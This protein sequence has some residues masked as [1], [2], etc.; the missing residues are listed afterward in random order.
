MAAV[1][2]DQVQI[3]LELRATKYLQDV[4]RAANQFDTDMARMSAA[5]GG[6]E[7][8]AQQAFSGIRA[9]GLSLAGAFSV[10]EILSYADA[11]ANLNKTLGNAGITGTKQSV[12]M[13]QL[14]QS[15][16]KNSVPL[17]DLVN[18]YGKVSQAQG[19]LGASS[20][21]M[22]RFVDGVAKALQVAG[23]S[24]T[25][26][27]GALLQL[28]QALG[29]GTIR[30]EEFNSI[31]EGARPVLQAVANA[32][33]TVG[34]SL[35]KL[36]DLMASG[37]LS[38]KE[39]FEAFNRGIDSVAVNAGQSAITVSQAVVKIQNA[40]TKYIGQTDESLGAT[41]RLAAG[42]SALADNFNKTADV[43]LKLVAVIAAAM[44]GRA[45]GPMIASLG[46]G[47]VA[48]ARFSAAVVSATY[49]A[50]GMGAAFRVV[51]SAIVGLGAAA[52]PVG[53][54]IAATLA[55]AVVTYVTSTDSATASTTAYAA[56][57]KKV[58]EQAAA[59]APAIADLNEKML[60]AQRASIEAGIEEASKRFN[61]AVA[62]MRASIDNNLGAMAGQFP[63]MGPQIA[64]VRDRL[65]EVVDKLQR[66]EIDAKQAAAEIKAIGDAN[67]IIGSLAGTFG[68][69]AGRIGDAAAAARV[70]AADLKAV[71]T[72]SVE[73][74]MRALSAQTAAAREAYGAGA[75]IDST[76]TQVVPSE[77]TATPSQI[78]NGAYMQN[79]IAQL[80]RR[81]A[82][83]A[84]NLRIED[85]IKK[86]VADN[87]QLASLP[88]ARQ[89]EL[90][91]SQIAAEDRRSEENRSGRGGRT[92]T[93]ATADDRFTRDMQDQRDRIAMMQLE[94]QI[95]GQSTQVQDQRRMALELEQ[96]ALRDAREEA[97][98]KGETDLSN[99][100]ITQTQRDQIEAVSRAYAEQAQQLRVV[101]ENQQR[102]KQATSEFYDTFKS[103][104]IGAITGA[105]SFA[106]AL[107]N[108]LKKLAD[109]AL[110]SAFDM[111]FKPAGGGGVSS[112]LSSAFSGFG[113][114]GGG[115]YV[116][117]SAFKARGGNVTK[118]Q[119][120]IV[121]EEQPE[122]FVPNESGRIIP[123]VAEFEKMTRRDS[124]VEDREEA[125]SPLMVARR[126]VATP[127]SS[128]GFSVPKLPDFGGLISR[129]EN[130]VSNY[131][132][133]PVIDARGADAEAVAR[134]ERTQAKMQAEFY[135]RT[136]AAV[137]EQQKRRQLR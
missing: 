22:L 72:A 77:L 98:R 37:G 124:D 130:F 30:A 36:R 40:F 135:S 1:T 104:M 82:L 6:A 133:A 25:A 97:R 51:G 115:G 111:I 137:K 34:G 129:N 107:A 5:A 21:D 76:Q 70:L 119:P 108:I 93:R 122:V 102:V 110:N 89:R 109:I 3:E 131:N 58:Q 113:G 8:K 80:E 44:I 31:M 125:P 49:A 103:S 127:D 66:G 74:Q 128:G 39:F 33:P 99:I 46:I 47:V 95:V 65:Q 112:W 23:S 55:A 100:T 11:W 86:L 106:D 27:R 136:N 114:G 123:S 12:V 14:Y 101:Q 105:N 59:T 15:A 41:S 84:E 67:P 90:A 7:R 118:G 116:P 16:Q 43:V 17:A 19:E 120:Y 92:S 132:F 42:L 134:L 45:I 60:S 73:A 32:I 68:S 75:R 94:M 64:A 54:I 10:S 50:A 20:G 9:A 38:S 56:A 88:P 69:L 78:Q 61:E 83:S 57:L 2:A 18:L 63:A 121:G 28:S 13:D 62:S 79:T 53:A 35:S 24:A 87:P 117:S 126:V 91:Q 52:G 96:K 26:S 71:G 85:A 29:S 4:T 48:L 81:N